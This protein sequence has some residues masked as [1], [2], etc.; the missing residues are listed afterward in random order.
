MSL[1]YGI[2][3]LFSGCYVAEY[4][5]SD[6]S[7]TNLESE[8]LCFSHQKC[9]SVNLPIFKAPHYYVALLNE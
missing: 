3:N 9:R 7:I 8:N 2:G 5:Q 1:Y 6:I 4:E